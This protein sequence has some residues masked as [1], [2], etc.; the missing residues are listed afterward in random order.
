MR[1]GEWECKARRKQFTVSLDTSFEDFH[2]PLHK[3]LMAMH[4]MNASKKHISSHQLHR[5]LGI[6]YKSAWFMTHRIRWAMRQ[7]G[8]KKPL[9]GVVEIDE[10]HVG[11]KMRQG[12]HS[13]KLGERPED[14]PSTVSNK[15]PV[16]SL[17]ER[18]GEVR[19]IHV[20]NVTANY[21]KEVVRENVAPSAQIMTDDTEH[22]GVV[23]RGFAPHSAVKH[24]AKE[25]WR[26]EPDGVLA[27]TNTVEGFFA[28]SKRGVCCSFHHVSK[29]HLRRYLA[30]FD[31]R[32]D[33]RDVD[34][35][36][37]RQ[38]AIKSVVGKRLTYYPAKG[39]ETPGLVN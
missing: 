39:E 24:R 11:G 36:E 31:S 15:A 9:F 22:Y 32:Y 5:M 7:G 10:T 16:L 8:P 21:L 19:S 12:P 37:R 17:V 27:T 4:L 6:I 3:W 29:Q 14:K 18:D 13:H 28:I 33:A 38:L 25:Y 35:G 26:R 20:A 34:D 1:P 23:G 30:Q 2:I